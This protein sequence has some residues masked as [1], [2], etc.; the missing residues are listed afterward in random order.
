MTLCPEAVIFHGHQMNAAGFVRQ[1]FIYGRGAHR[2]H[3]L[4]SDAAGCPKVKVEPFAFYFN[5]LSYPYRR[6]V[7]FNPF[8]LCS[9]LFVSQAANASGFFL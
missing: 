5:L 6:K 1:H 3:S 9:L 2:Y 4:K 7:G 8:L